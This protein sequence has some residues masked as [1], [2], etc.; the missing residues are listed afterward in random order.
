MQRLIGRT[1]IVTGGARGIG[2]STTKRFAE[3]GARVLIADIDEEAAQA[4]VQEIRDEGHVAEAFQ[5]DVAR[6]E[7]IKNMVAHVVSQWGRLDILVN[8]AFNPVMNV[9]G[10]AEDLSE[11]EWDRGMAMLV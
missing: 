8:N 1:A 7:D 3:E 10:T 11:E 4:K 9:V 2:G 6:H 5:V